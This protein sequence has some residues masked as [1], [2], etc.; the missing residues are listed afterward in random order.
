MKG[1][2]ITFEGGDCSG[3]TTIGNNVARDLNIS[4]VNELLLHPES[5]PWGTM[6][7]IDTNHPLFPA[8]LFRACIWDIIHYNPQEKFVVQISFAALRS[9]AYQAAQLEF[10][11]SKP[12]CHIFEQLVQYSPRP[13]NSF[14]LHADI[15][16]RTK[17]LLKREGSNIDRCSKDDK[18]ILANPDFVDCMC[19]HLKKISSSL[20]ATIID[21]TDL[22]IRKVTGIVEKFVAG[23][24]TTVHMVAVT[25]PN[26]EIIPAQPIQPDLDI[27]HKELARYAKFL[28]KK[29]G[30]PESLVE[31]ITV[32]FKKEEK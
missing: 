5:N 24:G 2:L 16:T 7:G 10:D 30:M 26:T 14:L 12:V 31:R 17:R 13:P 1:K 8:C 28:A 11:K 20:G 15:D 21:T 6:Q 32:P 23:D 4:H 27:L 22:T 29:H 9:T 18:L 3:K 25:T 19:E